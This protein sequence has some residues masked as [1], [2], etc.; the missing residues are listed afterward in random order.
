MKLASPLPVLIFAA[1][2]F[3]A[4]TAVFYL[5]FAAYPS[6]EIFRVLYITFF[7]C[8]YHIAMRVAVG[9]AVTL[10]HRRRPFDYD[11]PFFRQRRFEKKLYKTLKV[12]KWKR[13]VITAKPWQFDFD[14]RSPEELVFYMTQA[15]VVHEIIMILSFVP[16]LFIIPFGAAP[17]FIVTSVLAALID[18]LFVIVQRYNRPRVQRLMAYL[19]SRQK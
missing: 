6:A 17:V 9:E 16:L 11:S 8:L 3:A 4:G 10:Y 19:E 18:W 1:I 2:F 14:S 5:L 15:E 13:Y 7:T 12:G